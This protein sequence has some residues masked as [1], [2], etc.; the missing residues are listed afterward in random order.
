MKWAEYPDNNRWIEIPAPK[1][2]MPRPV[3]TTKADF[4]CQ[5]C[6]RI[7][8]AGEWAYGIN[9]HWYCYKCGTKRYET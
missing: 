4:R 6:G 2:K 9:L 3:V 5:D 8:Q 1:P 7:V